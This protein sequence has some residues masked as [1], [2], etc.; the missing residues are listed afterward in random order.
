MDNGGRRLVNDRRLNSLDY[1][2][3]RRNSH[4]RRSK[5]DR[6][7]GVER[8]SSS[9]FRAMVGMDRRIAFSYGNAGQPATT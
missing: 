1:F 7:N 6:R 4:E 3:D 8:R 2:P 9:G 5:K